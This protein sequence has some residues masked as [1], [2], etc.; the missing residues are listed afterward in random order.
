MDIDNRQ[1][2][3]IQKEGEQKPLTARVAYC[4]LKPLKDRKTISHDCEDSGSDIPA[5]SY[6]VGS[7]SDD[8]PA[9]SVSGSSQDLELDRDVF[10]TGYSGPKRRQAKTIPVQ[11]AC[12]IPAD[13][14]NMTDALNRRESLNDCHIDHF[15][16]MLQEQFPH[17]DGLQRCAVFESKNHHRIGTPSGKFLQILL[18]GGNHWITIS[19]MGCDDPGHI[20]IYDSIYTDFPKNSSKKVY[21][22]IAWLLF[23]DATQL[24]LHWVDVQHQR[25][26]TACGL[27]AIASAFAVCAGNQPEDYAWD[28]EM[29]WGHMTECLTTDNLTM[30]PF[31]G[32]R[33][34]VRIPQTRT[35]QLSCVCRQPTMSE[36]FMIQCVL[37][38]EWLHRRCENIHG[39]V[40]PGTI[41]HCSSCSK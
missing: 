35:Q 6:V 26:T 30:P 19:N 7:G 24:T 38:S 2:V 22:Q 13:I 15:S 36:C 32:I 18:L 21:G 27:Y 29:M 31:S 1:R 25:G 28:Q 40:V 37:C 20:K 9:P 39:K 8:P 23:T 10:I 41:F 33:V 4:Q 14:V 3:Q 16:A 12:K 5:S 11:K 17:V 34:H